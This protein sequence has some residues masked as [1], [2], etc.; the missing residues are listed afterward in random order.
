MGSNIIALLRMLLGAFL[1][2]GIV[3]A[4]D[5]PVQLGDYISVEY[6]DA[7]IQTRSPIKAGE[8]SDRRRYCKVEFD[9]KGKEIFFGIGNF[10]DSE[11]LYVTGPTLGNVRKVFGQM[12]V[13]LK[14][15]SP[16]EFSISIE[17]KTL[18]F[19]HVGSLKRFVAHNTIAGKYK[20][21]KGGL[22]TFTEEGLAIFPDRSFR[23]EVPT[24][25]MLGFDKLYEIPQHRDGIQYGFKVV[26]NELQLFKI[27]GEFVDEP[28]PNP[29]VTLT[30]IGDEE[31]KP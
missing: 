30:R 2:V 29:F 9:T 15:V 24:D 13:K 22:Y 18:V 25:L 28:E 8:R 16:S 19:R 23:Y 6:I 31:S 26:N 10:H 1:I 17:G 11:A 21:N 14:V 27:V 5:F 20:D 12:P 4:Q 7:L 3:A